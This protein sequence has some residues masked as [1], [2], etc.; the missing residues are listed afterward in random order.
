MTHSVDEKLIKEIAKL[1]KLTISHEE[2]VNYIPHMQKVLSHFSELETLNTEDV[3]P[4]ITPVDLV[5]HLREDQ[6]HKSIETEALL[7]VA[8]EKVGQLFRV[9]PV[10]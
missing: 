2:I 10:I 1:A 6:V 8:P 5:S 7:D 9:P 4:L 3:E